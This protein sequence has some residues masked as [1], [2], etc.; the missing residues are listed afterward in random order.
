[1][2]W[3]K[4]RRPDAMCR[5]IKTTL[6][7]DVLRC[8]SLEF[9]EKEVWLQVIGYNLIRALMV[10]AAWAHH[11]DLERMGFKGIVDTLRQ[12]TPL[13]ASRMFTFKHARQ[14]LLRVIAADALQLRP[15]RSEPRAVKRRP[16]NYQNLTKLRKKMVVSASRSLK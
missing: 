14:E 6:G 3:A 2:V 15:D 13:L 1:M 8:G 16:K 9:I 11:V 10:E 12:W 7:L 5:D 4:P